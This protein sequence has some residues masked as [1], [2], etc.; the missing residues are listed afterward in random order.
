MGILTLMVA[1]LSLMAGFRSFAGELVE[2]TRTLGSPEDWG[3]LTVFSEPPQLDVY[4]DGERWTTPV[5]TA[6][7]NGLSQAQNQGS[8]RGRTRGKGEDGQ[9]YLL[10]DRL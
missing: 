5:A 9:G 6:G 4:L 2:P 7:E 1:A 10:K 8:R 3:G